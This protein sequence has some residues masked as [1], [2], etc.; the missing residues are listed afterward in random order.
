MN[1]KGSLPHNVIITAEVYNDAYE[2]I[3]SEE[4]TMDIKDSEG[5]ELNFTFDI[6]ANN[7]YLNAGNLPTG[8][9]TFS[10]I[11]ELG[12][13]TFEETGSFTVV[14]VNIE[15]LSTRANHHMLYQLANNTNG[16][17]FLPA[18]GDQI[19]PELKNNNSL[20]ATSY[21]QEMVY[22]LLNLKWL[23]FVFL[24]LL[25]LEWFLRKFWGIY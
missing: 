2:Q 22:E 3:T 17:F 10:S 19:V 21:M 14:P 13:E 4:V 8:D 7:Y 18:D 23:F 15:N 6:Q 20:K 12:N 9:Y 5:N 25:S 1:K 11:V 24:L 16:K